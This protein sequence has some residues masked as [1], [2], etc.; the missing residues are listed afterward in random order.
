M[1]AERKVKVVKKAWT[2]EEDEL[3]Q[4]LVTLH[5]TANW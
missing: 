2:A 5:G 4:E 3:L 1:S